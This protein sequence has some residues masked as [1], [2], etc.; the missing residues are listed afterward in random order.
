MPMMWVKSPGM[1][2]SMQKAVAVVVIVFAA[3][4]LM[5]QPAEAADAV[6]AAANGVGDVF[7]AMIRFLNA[8]FD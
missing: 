7:Q 3:F 2:S 4:F 8:L 5:T 1:E 6:K